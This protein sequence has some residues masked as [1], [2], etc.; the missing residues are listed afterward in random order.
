M[1]PNRL[2]AR[3]DA[4]DV[5]SQS[6]APLAQ[7]VAEQAKYSAFLRAAL[8]VLQQP[9]NAAYLAVHRAARGR[10][11]MLCSTGEPCNV[12]ESMLA[13]VL[14]GEQLVQQGRMVA[15]LLDR[16]SGR[17]EVLVVLAKTPVDRELSVRIDAHA[18][19]L[20]IFGKLARDKESSER[21]LRRSQEILNLAI[22]WNKSKD[23]V[24]LLQ[25]I[26]EASTRLLESERA[27]IF[28]WNR[29]KR[30]L[31]AYPALGV[32]ADDFRI[33]DNVGVVGQVIQTG[34]TRR[35]DA[36]ASDQQAEIDRQVDKQLDFK[37]RSL[38][39]VPMVG[40]D[41][42]L[43]GAFEMINKLSGNFNDADEETLCELA[44]HA[45]VALEN[46]RQLEEVLTKKRRMADQA[47]SGVQLIG[48][49][50]AIER[51]RKSVLRVAP[52]DLAVLVLGENGTG[53]EVVSNLIHYHSNRRNELLVAVNCAAISES[54]LESELFGHEKGAFTD[55]HEARAGK[56]ELASGGTLFLD[57]I[58][59]MSL[60]G[61][62]KLL[63][64]L[65]EK[66]VVRVGGSLP[67]PTDVR[68]CAAT[69]QD[70]SELVKQKR[71][72]EDLF[73]RLNVVTLEIP[74]L[75]ERGE[76]VWL[77]AESF[78]QSFCA[79]A[80]RETL[81]VSP[82]ARKKLLAHS[83]PGNVREL[84]NMIERLAY[85]SQE[86][87][88]EAE[89][90]SF[91]HGAEKAGPEISLDLTLNDATREFQVDFINRQIQATGGNMT[92][93]AKRLGL[94]RSNLYRKMRQLGLDSPDDEET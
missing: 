28:L 63:R 92:D 9:L 71:F 21:K 67:I 25:E 35:I 74:P 66:V 36:D 38:L 61:Q 18:A 82:A 69:N 93:A 64:V 17:N 76:D 79:K 80:R 87:R 58:G 8:P 13:E 57:E 73:F 6:A 15:V 70:L 84:R 60:A 65:E 68:V 10:W 16:E 91:A 12:A 14:D 62:S 7:I 26:A 23:S 85:L 32:E 44:M 81:T 33:P 75:R 53:K 22:Q 56:F 46:S 43:L 42:K 94:H 88:I 41:G 37:T 30:E 48:E 72:R 11:R 31:V 3:L 54:L 45:T 24:Q 4:D 50:P 59:D 52:T 89:D 34:E 47:A 86:D 27:S 19:Q 2:I 83:W 55:A 51:L 39:C 29:P 1:Q 77:L 20:E 40:R 49:S 78:L 5:V 90:I